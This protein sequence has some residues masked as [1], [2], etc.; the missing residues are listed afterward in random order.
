LTHLKV[1]DPR[2]GIGV[3]WRNW[4]LD[5][6]TIWKNCY[7]VA[8]GVILSWFDIF[9]CREREIYWAYSARS[10]TK[11]SLV[12][13]NIVLSHREICTLI[14]SSNCFWHCFLIPKQDW[15]INVKH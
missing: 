5:S 10:S 12:N 4:R 2:D 6:L 11:I 14:S 3:F 1:R 15:E 13:R 9:C 8:V 7:H